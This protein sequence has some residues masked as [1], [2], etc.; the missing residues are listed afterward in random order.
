MRDFSVALSETDHKILESYK[1][2]LDGLADYLGEGFEFVLHSLHDLDRSVIKI[3]NGQYTGRR[4][5]SPITDLALSMLAKVEEQG[6]TGHISYFN[7]NKKGEP[8][9]SA[10]IVIRGEGGKAIGLLCINFYMNTPLFDVLH[11]FLPQAS[12]LRETT[13]AENYVEEVDDLIAEAVAEAS[14]KI[15]RDATI[16]NTN[17]NKEI[18]GLLYHK[19]IFNLKDAVVKVADQMGISK[20]TVYMHVRNL[21]NTQET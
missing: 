10:T 6:D 14:T 16:S 11:T 8:L 1:T 12:G 15:R 20:N 9:K 5:G 19:G 13:V 7:R 4:E 3:I 2:V 17:K 21:N 18:V